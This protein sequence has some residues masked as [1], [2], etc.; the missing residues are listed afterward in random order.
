MG[1]KNILTE[2]PLVSYLDGRVRVVCSKWQVSGGTELPP[3]LQW[4]D[5]GK[6][7]QGSGTWECL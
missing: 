3:H 2:K 7:N 4:Q 6:Q 5:V 1:E